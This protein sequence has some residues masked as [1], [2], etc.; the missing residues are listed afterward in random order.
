MS[1]DGLHTAKRAKLESSGLLSLPFDL[2][3]QIIG[4]VSD[5]SPLNDQP[6]P[7]EGQDCLQLLQV[8]KACRNVLLMRPHSL[9]VVSANHSKF[10]L[11]LQTEFE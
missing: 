2:I 9:S 10:G 4:F 6:P 8:N 7:L 5:Q 3:L 1:N 11:C